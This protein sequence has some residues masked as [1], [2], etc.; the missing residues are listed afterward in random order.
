MFDVWSPAHS[1]V[2]IGLETFQKS[3]EVE[4]NNFKLNYEELRLRVDLLPLSMYLELNSLLFFSSLLEQKFYL[5][6]IPIPRNAEKRKNLLFIL[7][8]SQQKE[9]DMS[10]STERVGLP[11]FLEMKWIR[12]V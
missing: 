8:K 11:I 3:T 2:S 9:P 4:T 10:S 6:L 7:K 12:L 5:C 1:R